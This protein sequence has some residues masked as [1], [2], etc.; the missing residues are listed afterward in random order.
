MWS[1]SAAYRLKG[2]NAMS[3]Q[4]FKQIGAGAFLSLHLTIFV[5]LLVTGF[6]EPNLKYILFALFVALF[7]PLHFEDRPLWKGK[8]K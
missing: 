8:K 7:F 6:S 2:E 4:V 1:G 5:N 3:K